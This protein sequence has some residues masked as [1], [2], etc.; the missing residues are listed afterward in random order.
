M[1]PS[2]AAKRSRVGDSG[3]DGDGDVNVA[4]DSRLDLRYCFALVLDCHSDV[5]DELEIPSQSVVENHLKVLQAL[6]RSGLRAVMLERSEAT[7]DSVVVLVSASGERN[8]ELVDDRGILSSEQKREMRQRYVRAGVLL[9]DL[10]GGSKN[11][12]SFKISKHMSLREL[13]ITPAMEIKLTDK[14]LRRSLTHAMG[15]IDFDMSNMSCLSLSSCFPLHDNI[16]NKRL[17]RRAMKTP[18]I[19]CMPPWKKPEYTVDDFVDEVYQYLGVHCAIYFAFLTFYTR[20][21]VPVALSL[22]LFYLAFRFVAWNEYVMLLAIV[23]CVTTSVWGPYLVRSWKQE[24]HRLL[25][26]WGILNRGKSEPTKNLHDPEYV[27]KKDPETGRLERLYD[28]KG[29]RL[30][31]KLGLPLL[32][33]INCCFMFAVVIMFVQFWA[34]GKMA[35][36]CACCQYVVD[37]TA[38]NPSWLERASNDIS[39]WSDSPENCM[40]PYDLESFRVAHEAELLPE[41]CVHFVNCFNWYKVVVFISDR[42][43]MILIQGIV[44][45]LAI[46]IFQFQAFLKLMTKITKFENWD[47][48]ENFE[49]ARVQKQFV[50][51]WLN[52]YCWYWFI[53]FVAVPFGK[54]LQISLIQFG[55]GF[56]LPPHGWKDRIIQV[57]EA[58][59]TP[60]V[61]TAFL[62][63]LLDTVVPYLVAKIAHRHAMLERALRRKLIKVGLTPAIMHR[64]SAKAMFHLRPGK[65][66]KEGENGSDDDKEEGKDKIESQSSDHEKLFHSLHTN[67][68]IVIRLMRKRAKI[69]QNQSKKRKKSNLRFRNVVND[70]F[71]DLLRRGNSFVKKTSTNINVDPVT[72]MMHGMKKAAKS[73]ERV[74]KKVKS[75]GYKAMKTGT[76]QLKEGLK[77]VK[78]TTIGLGQQIQAGMSSRRLNILAEIENT[79]HEMW[80]SA[81]ERHGDVESNTL[82]ANRLMYSLTNDEVIV[83]IA[84]RASAHG[85]LQALVSRPAFQQKLAH[86]MNMTD[87]VTEN[88]LRSFCLSE[89]LWHDFTTLSSKLRLAYLSQ[90]GTPH[91]VGENTSSEEKNLATGNKHRRSRLDHRM[92]IV[93]KNRARNVLSTLAMSIRK[94]TIAKISHHNDDLRKNEDEECMVTE[95]R[96]TRDVYN[97]YLHALSKAVNSTAD[98]DVAVN[99]LSTSPDNN[100]YDAEEVIIQSHKP[101]Y[102]CHED[103]LDMILQLGYLLQFAACW[104]F[105]FL[106]ALVN[107]WFEIQGDLFRCAWDC[108]RPVPRDHQTIREWED[109]IWWTPLISVPVTA[110]LV[111]LSTGQLERWGGTCQDEMKENIMMPS[112]DCVTN[113]L[114]RPLVWLTLIFVLEGVVLATYALVP[115]YSSLVR[116]HEE[117]RLES[118]QERLA[119]MLVPQFSDHLY[120]CLKDIFFFVR[121]SS[122]SDECKTK[123]DNDNRID[124]EG[125][126]RLL[127]MLQD[128]RKLPRLTSSQISTLFTQM[129]ILS[130]HSISFSDFSAGLV[131]AYEDYTLRNLELEKLNSDNKFVDSLRNSIFKTNGRNRSFYSNSNKEGLHRR[132]RVLSS[133]RN[134]TTTTMSSS[135][136]ERRSSSSSSSGS[137][138]SN[139]T[140]KKNGGDG[141]NRLKSLIR[142]KVINSIRKRKLK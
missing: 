85:S 61:A 42:W 28:P 75:K 52:M 56:L 80:T 48:N 2:A 11:L 46:D 107:N 21:I 99:V 14:I 23:G 119:D 16:F 63:L 84:Q 33:I 141:K 106:C 36:T 35:P 142:E 55:F 10:E 47:T 74:V 135:Q 30:W 44:M 22:T 126:K 81:V 49:K 5:K 108:S 65:N 111:V 139:N 98:E 117:K 18:F 29:H 77:A 138:K 40:T 45:G 137:R 50:F 130:K 26:R 57:D 127:N 104:P 116:K 132:D 95:S 51:V 140:T 105:T 27:L 71:K 41:T 20:K 32:F 6:Q 91:C 109:V 12:F 103:Y 73:T 134:S 86:H 67:A 34:Y 122:S 121:A 128:S 9:T 64:I 133:T 124:L 92:F 24:N 68:N 76:G 120:N 59:V 131:Q 8:G 79:F 54:S 60:L 100:E 7:M 88:T 123:N 118:R 102:D 72:K 70:H 78:M 4:T 19:F 114:L 101:S 17:V 136:I 90:Y 38:A 83:E 58:F 96:L 93:E 66:N 31:V 97:A 3:Y 87:V 112:E 89:N 94:D 125:L 15:G 115:Q 129:D 37:K 82:S 113:R 13:Q 43:Y 69:R 1:T 53:A 25:L 39:E 62:N 110:G